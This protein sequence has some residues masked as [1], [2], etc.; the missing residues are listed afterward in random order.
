MFDTSPL[1]ALFKSYYRARFPSLWDKFDVLVADGHIVSTRE[2]GRE[3]EDGPVESLR[4]WAASNG[5]VFATPTAAEGS[6]VA[7]IYGVQHFQQ[8]IEQRKLLRGGRN[9]DSFVIAKAAVDGKTV[10][11]MELFKEGGAKIPNICSHFGVPHLSLEQF[12]E[13]EGWTF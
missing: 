12:M 13:A 5:P 2:V 9:A 3:I 8:N 7:Q 4:T 6:F 1:S 11:S 10:V